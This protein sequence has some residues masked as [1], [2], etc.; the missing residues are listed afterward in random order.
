MYVFIFSMMYD[1]IIR[2]RSKVICC[3]GKKDNFFDY[4][5]GRSKISITLLF[6]VVGSTLT[7]YQ[8]IV[9][10]LNYLPLQL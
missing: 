2:E 10:M 1:K 7:C 6:K 8:K 5:S 4:F 3:S 9:H